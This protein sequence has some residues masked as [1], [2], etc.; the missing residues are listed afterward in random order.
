MGVVVVVAAAVLVGIEAAVVT[1]TDDEV[2]AVAAV[3]FL[4][5]DFFDFFGASPL[6]ISFPVLPMVGVFCKGIVIADA[7]WLIPLL[8]PL[9]LSL[10]C[11]C[12]R[13]MSYAV[14]IDFSSIFCG[15]GKSSRASRR[16]LRSERP[17]PA[18]WFSQCI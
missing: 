18:R 11:V 15:Q 10:F 14:F 1:A 2:I 7:S 9:P 13:L 6:N 17:W 12:L 16:E 5:R 3:D 4:L 8:L